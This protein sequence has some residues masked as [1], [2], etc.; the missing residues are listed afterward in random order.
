M[1]VESRA[2]FLNHSEDG[3]LALGS[4]DYKPCTLHRHTQ[5]ET[6]TPI[7]MATRC[8]ADFRTTRLDGKGFEQWLFSYR[9]GLVQENQV[10]PRDETGGGPWYLDRREL[11]EDWAREEA[12]VKSSFS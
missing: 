6:V 11:F 3:V 7:T 8:L 10:L 9:V 4:T 12:P 2:D 5:T 1:R